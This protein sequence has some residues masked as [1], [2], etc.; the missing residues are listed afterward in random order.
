MF[1]GSVRGWRSRISC[2]CVLSPLAGQPWRHHQ[3]I[4]RGRRQERIVGG[5]NTCRSGDDVLN[6]NHSEHPG[7]TVRTEETLTAGAPEMQKLV[8]IGAPHPRYRPEGGRRGPSR[9]PQDAE[10]LARRHRIGDLRALRRAGATAPGKL[11]REPGPAAA[12]SQGD[13]GKD[14][15]RANARFLRAPAVRPSSRVSRSSSQTTRP[16]SIRPRRTRRRALKHL[17]WF[18]QKHGLHYRAASYPQSPFYHFAIV[19]ALALVE[20]VV[21]RGVLRGGQRLRSAGRRPDRHDALD[22]QCQSGDS[23]RGAFF[24][25]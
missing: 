13:G 18:Q 3:T 9:Q 16:P 19:A 6:L 8:E 2:S 14:R 1:T 5:E 4:A 10:R 17:R 11:R 25:T 7:P 21:A 23:R 22:R 24:G 20:W 12:R 15:R